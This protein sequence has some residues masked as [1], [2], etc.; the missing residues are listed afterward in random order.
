LLGCGRNFCI[1]F[2]PKGLEHEKMDGD[3]DRYRQQKQDHPERGPIIQMLKLI[4]AHK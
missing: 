1:L 2:R 4:D 3:A